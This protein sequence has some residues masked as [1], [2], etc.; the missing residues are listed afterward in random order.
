[1]PVVATVVELELTIAGDVASFDDT[2]KASLK[3]SLKTELNCLEKDGCFL[4]VRVSAAGSINVAAILTI[5]D[6]AGGNATAVQQSAN[7]LAAQPAASLTSSLG[8]TVTATPTVQVSTGVTVPL[9]VAPP[10]PSLPPT[11]PPTPPP[12]TPPP[13]SPP[14][15]SP[16][17][18]VAATPTQVAASPSTSPSTPTAGPNGGGSNQAGKG[19]GG[20]G[21][22]PIGAIA[23]AGG[24]VCVLLLLFIS[25]RMAGK[26]KTGKANVSIPVQPGHTSAAV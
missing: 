3:E 2:Q 26:V 8:V 14:P 5:P 1:M 17:P 18:P 23:G 13:P 25:V 11:P 21:D 20:D 15:P 4:E 16:S 22:L 12:P 9:A 19:S 6:A 7:T 10:P 24:G